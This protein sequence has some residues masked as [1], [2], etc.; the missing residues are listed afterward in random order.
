MAPSLSKA[1][2]SPNTHP[3]PYRNTPRGAVQ[4]TTP[5]PPYSKP[6]LATTAGNGTTTGRNTR[7]QHTTH[8][9]DPP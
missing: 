3:S 9:G 7:P 1:M 4:F 6:T 2:G 5:F 8:Q